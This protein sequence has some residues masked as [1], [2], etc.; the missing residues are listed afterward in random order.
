MWF[1]DK[2]SIKKFFGSFDCFFINQKTRPDSDRVFNVVSLLP[3]LNVTPNL[4]AH[5][6]K[7]L[8]I[9]IWCIV[10]YSH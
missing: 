8:G 3:F 1:F 4:I 5:L 6:D 7:D 2:K 10:P 9:F